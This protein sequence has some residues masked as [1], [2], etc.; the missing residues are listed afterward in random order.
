MVSHSTSI[1]TIIY[2]IIPKNLFFPYL[3]QYH[4]TPSHLNNPDTESYQDILLSSLDDNNPFNQ[5]QLHTSIKPIARPKANSHLPPTYQ[6]LPFL[7]HMIFLMIPLPRLTPILKCS[8]NLFIILPPFPEHFLVL[9]TPLNVYLTLPPMLK[10]HLFI[11]E[12]LIYRMNCG[13][14]LV[15]TTTPRNLLLVSQLEIIIPFV[16]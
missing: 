4:S 8:I 12:L 3:R 15:K 16:S 11:F 2:H 7:V 5:F 1:E 14:F 9:L 10:L 6:I 13:R